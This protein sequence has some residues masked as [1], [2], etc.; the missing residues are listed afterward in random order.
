MT[1]YIDSFTD[2]LKEVAVRMAEERAK[3]TPLPPYSELRIATVKRMMQFLLGIHATHMSWYRK[4]AWLYL[5]ADGDEVACSTVDDVVDAVLDDLYPDYDRHYGDYIL[6][7]LY[8][9]IRDQFNHGVQDCWTYRGHS[10]PRGAG[11]TVLSRYQLLG[12][13]ESLLGFPVERMAQHAQAETN[14]QLRNYWGDGERL[15][16]YVGA[17]MAIVRPPGGR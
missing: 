6:Q 16:T 3:R 10:V 14:T 13:D 2:H 11:V 5:R 1:D 9:E 7:R 4:D 8:D 17:L 12:S 15:L